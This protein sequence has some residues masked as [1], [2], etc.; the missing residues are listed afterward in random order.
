MFK[1]SSVCIVRLDLIIVK[2]LI[3]YISNSFFF[4]KT[5][6]KLDLAIERCFYFGKFQT[7][8]GFICPFQV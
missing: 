7:I 8:I 1:R 2:R 3:Y 5:I 6:D 4:I